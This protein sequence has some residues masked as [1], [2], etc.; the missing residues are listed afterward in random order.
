MSSRSRV[1][2]EG[3]STALKNAEYGFDGAHALSPGGSDGI[4]ILTR[5]HR[6]EN[7]MMRKVSN[8]FLDR[9]DSGI[10]EIA[11]ELNCIAETLIPVRLVS[12][13]MR[14]LG[15]LYRADQEDTLVLVDFDN[16]K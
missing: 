2:I 6:P 8:R 15:I 12:H 3:V 1:E 9:P 5:D 10:K 13:H 7:E 11:D 14:L 16:T 4:F